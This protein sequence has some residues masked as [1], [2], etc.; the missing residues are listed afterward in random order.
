M[1]TRR[2]VTKFKST[3]DP[4]GDDPRATTSGYRPAPGQDRRARAFAGAAGPPARLPFRAGAD[5]RVDADPRGAGLSLVPRVG[6][7]SAY[8]AGAAARGHRVR[9]QSVLR[10]IVR[11]R[12]GRIV[13]PGR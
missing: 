2:S 5:H 9:G 11:R 8:R 12:H 4:T 6:P 1:A 3:H 10:R 13:E 7:L